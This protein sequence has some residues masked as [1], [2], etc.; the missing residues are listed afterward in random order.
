[1]SANY[2]FRICQDNGYVFRLY[3]N[4]NK[5]Q[6][7]GESIAYDTEKEC[8]LALVAFRSIVK[9]HN[10]KL[11]IEEKNDESKY[12]PYLENEG[13]TVFF[14]PNGYD[15]KNQCDSWIKRICNNIEAELKSSD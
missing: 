1:M 15:E 11:H 7:I 14:R 9:Q 8:R 10:I 4:N 5:G 13:K 6:M 3:P 12:Y 2:E